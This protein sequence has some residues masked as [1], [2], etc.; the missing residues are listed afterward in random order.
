MFFFFDMLSADPLSDRAY[1]NTHDIREYRHTH[2]QTT[3][4]HT[5]PHHQQQRQQQQ[6]QQKAA[7][8]AS[9]KQQA[10]SSKQQTTDNNRIK[11]ISSPLVKSF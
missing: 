9:N 1:E 2:T 7:E 11:R 10:A 8:T 3:P 5:T 4:H 6:K